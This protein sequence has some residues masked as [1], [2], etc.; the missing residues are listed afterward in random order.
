MTGRPTVLVVD[1]EPGM[2]RTVTRILEGEH[3]VLRAASSAEAEAHLEAGDIDLALV[4]VRMPQPDGFALLERIRRRWP[5]TD[6]IMMTGSVADT[7]QKLV[8]AIEAGAFYFITKPF[9]RPVL[10][11]LV[12]RCLQ[13]RRLDREQRDRVQALQRELRLAR[14]FQ[15]S[16]L[17][18]SPLRA[19]DCTVWSTLRPAEDLSGDFV[20]HGVLSDGAPWVFLADVCGHGAAAA[21]V[22]GIVKAALSATLGGGAGPRDAARALRAAARPLPDDLYFTFFLG[23]LEGDALRHVNAGH[24]AGLL[25][26]DGQVRQLESTEP[27]AHPDLLAMGAEPATAPLP[28]GARLLLYSDGLS[29]ARDPDGATFGAERLRPPLAE[30]APDVVLERCLA[31]VDAFVRG[32][33][34]DDDQALLLLARA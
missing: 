11:A 9:E 13:L 25:Q 1:D 5:D 22:T 31:A 34:A 15:Q 4:D 2:V 12:E 30:A 14:S 7:D 23:W 21:M 29:E 17:P 33:P 16:L 6:V 18:R 19:G 3:R 28:P 24:P 26:A 8:Q 27:M 32:R 10:L 20:D